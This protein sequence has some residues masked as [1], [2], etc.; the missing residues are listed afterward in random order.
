M[1]ESILFT[2][3]LEGGRGAK[4]VLLQTETLETNW[5]GEARVEVSLHVIHVN[6]IVRSLRS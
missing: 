6:L 1:G 3:H 5:V 2:I 4:L